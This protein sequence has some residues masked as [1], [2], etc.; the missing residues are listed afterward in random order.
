MP[1]SIELKRPNPAL[2]REPYPDLPARVVAIVDAF[3]LRENVLLFSDDHSAVRDVRRIAP[4][5]A[6]TITLGGAIFLE[7]VAIARQA[8]ADGIAIYWSYASRQLVET[9]HAAGLHVFGFGLGDD[10][11]RKT[12]LEAMLANGTDILS[13]GA[14]DKLRA[15]VDDWRSRS[16]ASSR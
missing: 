13:G 11:S 8:G 7:P 1:L 6:T 4:D 12:E 2:G 14:P 9:C 15:F 5:I 3:D 10:L 16:C